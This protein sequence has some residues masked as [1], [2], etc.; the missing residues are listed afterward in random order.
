MNFDDLHDPDPSR[1]DVATLAAVGRRA[2]QLRRRRTSL[3]AAGATLAVVALAVPVTVW[4]TRDDD[5]HR[6]VTTATTPPT[7]TTPV[8]GTSTTTSSS[9]TST[10]TSTTAPSPPPPPT[11]PAAAGVALLAIREDGDP[12]IIA[13]DGTATVVY[14]GN[15]CGLR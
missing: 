15:D 13:P 12:V 1:P 8:P 6:I 7:S 5:D 2:R 11:V 4:L 9:T 10:T 14:D 3:R